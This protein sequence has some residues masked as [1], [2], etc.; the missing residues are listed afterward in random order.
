MPVSDRDVKR[1]IKS[2]LINPTDTKIFQPGWS[3][4]RV[5]WRGVVCGW[6][7]EFAPDGRKI[8]MA[9]PRVRALP[10]GRAGAA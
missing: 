5:L 9:T 8:D 3:S 4:F 7:V 2:G 6:L 10:S 1:W